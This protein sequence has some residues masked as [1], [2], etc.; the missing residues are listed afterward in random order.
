MNKIRTALVDD[1]QIVRDGIKAL[2]LSSQ[3]IDVV[4]EVSNAYEL[5][6]LLKKVEVDIILLDINLP[7]VSGI[8]ACKIIKKEYHGIKV[9]MLS[10]YNNEDFVYNSIRAGA[11]GYLEKNTTKKELQN[12]INEIYMGGEYFSKSISEVIFKSV[13]NKTKAGVEDVNSG[14]DA[15]TQREKEI[16]HF[17][18]EG[19]SNS[20]ISQKL[21]ISIR[22][23]EK[24]KTNLMKKLGVSNTVELVKY[25]IRN[26]LIH[27]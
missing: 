6:D 23:V 25:A 8:E 9:L 20:E 27:L 7:K 1:H 24:H 18:I 17:V 4:G 2:L 14:I 15:L 5:Y 13:V 19:L 22:T 12:A 10:M 26:K 21:V 3:N 11:N 16:L